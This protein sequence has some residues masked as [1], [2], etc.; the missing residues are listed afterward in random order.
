MSNRHQ[1]FRGAA[2]RAAAFL[3][4]R[5]AALLAVLMWMFPVCTHVADEVFSVPTASKSGVS[6]A[7]TA[8][9]DAAHECPDMGHGPGETHCRPAAGA[10]ANLASPV[11]VPSPQAV[12]TTVA[13]RPPD[14]PAARGEPGFL[15][16]TPGI[17]QLQVQRT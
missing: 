5:C 14:S 11:A 16:H 13:V 15:V 10:V 2:Q 12:D 9:E 8:P 1:S 3:A 7:A 6:T 4:L 17:H